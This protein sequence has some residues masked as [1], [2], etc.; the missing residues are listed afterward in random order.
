[1]PDR[2]LVIPD[3]SVATVERILR[4]SIAADATEIR[5][6]TTLA[7]AYFDRPAGRDVDAQLGAAKSQ[8]DVAE[9]LLGQ[10]A[11]NP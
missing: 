4:R 2:T 1:V 8:R 3:E 9:A 11:P 5:R 7:T 10:L 6:L